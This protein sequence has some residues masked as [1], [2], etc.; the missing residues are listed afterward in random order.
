VRDARVLGIIAGVPAGIVYFVVF[1]F[2]LWKS[3]AV[4]FFVASLYAVLAGIF[5]TLV[6]IAEKLDIDL[7]RD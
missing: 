6:K 4:G 1:G 5:L 2:H 3:L 7:D